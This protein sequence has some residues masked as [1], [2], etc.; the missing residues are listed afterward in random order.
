M[1][2]CEA[3]TRYARTAIALHWLIAMLVVAQIA[4]GWWMLGI[5]KRPV[6]PRVDA[7]NLHK[8]IGLA[9]LLMMMMRVA[10]RATHAPPPLP[11]MP[12]W[13]AQLARATHLLLYVAL[14]IQPLAGY[15]GSEFS[16]YPVRFFGMTLPSWAGR[17][18]ALKDALSTIHLA[19]GWAIVALA[20]LHAAAALKHALIDRDGFLARMGIGRD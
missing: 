7:F 17:N 13:Q 1:R 9:V 15:L 12:S 19:V 6:G 11:A 14:L 18:L 8:S 16:G 5:E 2:V 3:P 20:A 4:W 10:W